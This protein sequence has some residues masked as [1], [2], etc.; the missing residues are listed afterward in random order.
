M[1]EIKVAERTTAS[2]DFHIVKEAVLERYRRLYRRHSPGGPQTRKRDVSQR[3]L[4]AGSYTV[5]ITQ[6]ALTMDNTFRIERYA[7]GFALAR[8]MLEALLKQAM[9]LSH[10][11]DDDDWKSIADRRIKVTRRNLADLSTRTGWPDVGPMWRGLKPWLN[12]FVHGGRGQLTSNPINEDSKPV[13]EGAWFW[14]AMLV[15]SLATL[16]AHGF[17]WA[18]LG[19]D[20]RA[21]RVLDDLAEENWNRITISRNGQTVHIVGPSPAKTT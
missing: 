9:L 11:G 12:D 5:I 10:D 17:L 15:A 2:S 4:V 14:T 8:P 18:H 13:Y 16:A 6:H 7:S 20:D 19:D 21:K 1:Y 3:E